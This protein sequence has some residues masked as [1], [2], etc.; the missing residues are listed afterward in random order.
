MATD[1]EITMNHSSDDG[2]IA[3]I[4]ELRRMLSDRLQALEGMRGQR[5]GF[6]LEVDRLR[7]QIAEQAATIEYLKEAVT[8]KDKHLADHLL[9]LENDNARLAGS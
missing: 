5:D 9:E 4:K 6:V 7:G 3:E 1:Q 2:A 8:R